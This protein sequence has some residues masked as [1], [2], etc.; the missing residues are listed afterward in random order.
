MS[1]RTYVAAGTLKRQ[2]ELVLQ[3]HPEIREAVE[4]MHMEILPFVCSE[5]GEDIVME[6][7][8]AMDAIERKWPMVCL[9]CICRAKS[10]PYP[11]SNLGAT[12]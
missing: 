6:K 4:S 3:T 9:A 11:D 10:I 12:Q 5:C 1:D 2:W 7:H 8:A